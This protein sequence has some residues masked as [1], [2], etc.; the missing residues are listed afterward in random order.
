MLQFT[1][2]MEQLLCAKIRHV[3]TVAQ[4]TLVDEYL[5]LCE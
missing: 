3:I 1:Q 4:R 5:K 2:Q